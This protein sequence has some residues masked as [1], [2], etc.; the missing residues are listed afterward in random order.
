MPAAQRKP[1]VAASQEFLSSS[2]ERSLPLLV[3][4]CHLS[5]MKLGSSR[6]TERVSFLGWWS[7]EQRLRVLAN[8]SFPIVQFDSNLKP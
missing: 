7:L 8:G 6:S 3:Q 5:P 2:P 1:T 4:F